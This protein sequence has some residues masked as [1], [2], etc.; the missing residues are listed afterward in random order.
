MLRG[1]IV[2]QSALPIIGCVLLRQVCFVMAILNHDA[3]GL[4]VKSQAWTWL[5]GVMVLQSALP[6]NG[7][8]LLCP[9]ERRA[10]ER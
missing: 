5:C 7:C 4:A 1:V 3:C 8:E 10:L 2:L 6:F 9:S